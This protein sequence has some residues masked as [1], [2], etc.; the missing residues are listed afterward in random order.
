M[1]RCALLAALL[2]LSPWRYTVDGIEGNPSIGGPHLQG[3]P[4]PTSKARR[5]VDLPPSEQSG[6][7]LDALD[8]LEREA[9]V[10]LAYSHSVVRPADSQTL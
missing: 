9:T 6:D 3:L 1:P 2:E 5:E 8:A 10:E 4:H 7:G